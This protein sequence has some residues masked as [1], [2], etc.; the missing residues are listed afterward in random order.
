MPQREFKRSLPPVQASGRAQSRTGARLSLTKWT[1]IVLS[2][3]VAWKR[4]RRSNGSPASDFETAVASSRLLT[5]AAGPMSEYPAFSRLIRARSVISLA[6]AVSKVERARG[7][8]ATRGLVFD[9]IW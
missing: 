7:T 6:R 3:K 9:I 4:T 5:E 8:N 2:V 1:V